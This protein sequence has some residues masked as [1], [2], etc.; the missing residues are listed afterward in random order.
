MGLWA[1]GVAAEA[2]RGGR[3]FFQILVQFEQFDRAITTLPALSERLLNHHTKSKADSQTITMGFTDLVSDGG[4]QRM[5]STILLI[6][7]LLH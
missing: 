4:L 5:F 2:W 6:R 7:R 3:I 1:L